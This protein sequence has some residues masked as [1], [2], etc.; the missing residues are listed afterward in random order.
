MERSDIAERL[1]R[2]LGEN[3]RT[4]TGIERSCLSGKGDWMVSGTSGR[5]DETRQTG[6]YKVY[7]AIFSSNAAQMF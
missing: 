1:L 3:E 6:Q 2:T 4:P 7:V 5:L